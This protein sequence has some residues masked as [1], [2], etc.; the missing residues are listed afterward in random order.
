MVKEPEAMGQAK[1]TKQLRW[2][3]P[4]RL[5]LPKGPYVVGCVDVMT[6][7]SASGCFIRLHYPTSLRDAKAHKRNWPKWFMGKDYFEGFVDS[8]NLNPPSAQYIKLILGGIK[9]PAVWREPPLG[10]GVTPGEGEESPGSADEKCK[11]G[12]RGPPPPPLDT[13][14]VAFLSHGLGAC[15]FSYSTICLEMASRGFVVVAVEHRDHTACSTYYLVPEESGE[16]RREHLEFWKL[17]KKEYTLRNRQAHLR[18]AEIRRAVDLME[19]INEGRPVHNLLDPTFPFQDFQGRLDFSK[20]VIIG[21]SFGGATT[22]LSLA[23]DPRLRIGIAL[24]AWMY[25]VKRVA[26]LPL[27]LSTQPI[28]F[29]NMQYFQKRHNLDEMRRLLEMATSPE[30]VPEGTPSPER[31]VVT[32]RHAIHEDQ[33]DSAYFIGWPFGIVVGQQSVAPSPLVSS[34]NTRLILQ[35]LSKQIDSV[36]LGE[37]ERFLAKWKWLLKEGLPAEEDKGECSTSDSGSEVGS[38]TS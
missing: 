31:R 28:L 1:K 8:M 2:W 13:L 3:N 11:G 34:V 4:R 18:S 36:D 6:G 10:R 12:A 20:A 23:K 35:F 37:H 22:L 25:P 30:V 26:D 16:L 15:R 9:I 27:R 29:V 17:E 14:P 33:S 7:S 19:D 24:D 21:H 5:P 38:T 32:I